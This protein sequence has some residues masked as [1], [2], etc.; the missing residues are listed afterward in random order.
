MKEPRSA[1][2]IPAANEKM[3][4]KVGQLPADLILLDLED[5]VLNKD[6]EKARELC[7]ETLKEFS[8]TS[9]AL[10]VRI[11]SF[12]S[13]LA[14]ADLR[15]IVRYKPI[16]IMLPKVDGITALIKAADL[17]SRLESENH[18]AQSSIG[19]LALTAEQPGAILRMG[20][21]EQVQG[22]LRGMTWGAEDLGV[23]IGASEKTDSEGNWLLP[24][25]WA[26]SACLLKARDLGVQAIDT[27]YAAFTDDDGLKRD[28]Q[29]AK[30]LGFTGKLA[31][32]PGQLATINSVFRPS[33]AEIERAQNI[34]SAFESNPTDGA[35]QY[36][37][38]M[39]DYPH[40]RQAEKLL[41]RSRDF[42][43]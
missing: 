39:L 25:A 21:I 34:L 23:E 10:G 5:S 13:G 26:Q 22:R 33:D 32:H 38:K 18:I 43:Q 20:E 14:E 28:A 8:T 40:R 31:I 9:Q 17:L 36:G 1:L 42:D 11:N 12:E 15:A 35:I 24:F 6:K 37:G 19:I 4:A 3:L 29:R 30:R 2:F 16:V 41:A 27:V 7:A